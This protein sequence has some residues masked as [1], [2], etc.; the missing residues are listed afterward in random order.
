M[1]DD[2]LAELGRQ[3]PAD[4]ARS[5]LIGALPTESDSKSKRGR[6][7]NSALPLSGEDMDA[8]LRSIRRYITPKELAALLHWHLET[9]YRKIKAGMPADRDVGEEGKGWRLK[10]YPPKIAN[11]LRECRD[12]RKRLIRSTLVSQAQASDRATCAPVKKG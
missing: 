1:G 6:L 9:V 5:S 12:A 3:I 10:I 4:L 2:L 7:P 11:W 8:R